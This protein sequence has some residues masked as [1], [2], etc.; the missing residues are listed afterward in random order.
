MSPEESYITELG[1]TCGKTAQ[2]LEELRRFHEKEEREFQVRRGR[3]EKLG[4]TLG[5]TNR[6]V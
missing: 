4:I 6:L 1:N 3:G 2:N 5:A